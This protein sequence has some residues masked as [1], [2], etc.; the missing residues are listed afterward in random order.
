MKALILLLGSLAVYASV[1][2]YADSNTFLNVQDAMAAEAPIDSDSN[3]LM[4]ELCESY[5]NDE[6]LKGDARDANIKDCLASM[7]TDLSDMET[8]ASSADPEDQPVDDEATHPEAL[9]ANEL[10]EKPLPGSEELVPKT[11]AKTE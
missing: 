9:I 4:Q 1:P 7:T 3:K 11:T 6:G 2:S 10:V 5:A 8:V